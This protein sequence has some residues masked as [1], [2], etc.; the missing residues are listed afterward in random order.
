[1]KLLTWVR[2]AH[3]DGGG[4]AMVEIGR[5]FTVTPLD[6]DA[7]DALQRLDRVGVGQLANIL[8]VDR[9]DDLIGVALDRLGER[10]DSRTPVTTMSWSLAVP[11]AA[12]SAVTLPVA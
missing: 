10:R 1:M 7:G 5:A 2:A 4:G 11:C 6:L 12:W 8:C 3:G 9:V